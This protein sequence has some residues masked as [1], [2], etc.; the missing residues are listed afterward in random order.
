MTGERVWEQPWPAADPGLLANETIQLVVQL[1]GKVIDRLDAPAEASRE[2]LE[3]LARASAKLASR[4]NGQQI[5]KAIVVPGK[6]VNF[7]VR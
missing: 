4:L 5:D 7:V 1:N 3:E 2:E 6:L